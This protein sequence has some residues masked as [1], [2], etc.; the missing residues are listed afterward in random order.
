MA[1]YIRYDKDGYI[2]DKY[3]SADGSDLKGNILK[4]PHEDFIAITKY[5]WVK[6]GVLVEMNQTEKD[7]YDVLLAEQEAEEKR[8]QIDNLDVDVKALAMALI[9]LGVITETQLKDRL[10]TDAGVS[11]IGP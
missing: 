8:T 1:E 4:V 9:N 3:G 5:H 10:K 2:T 7:A 11:L 6:G